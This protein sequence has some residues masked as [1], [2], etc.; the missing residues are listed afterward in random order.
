[1]HDEPITVAGDGSQTRSICYI[2]DT[3][4]G[5]LAL[6]ASSESGPINIGNGD[7]MSMLELAERIEQLVGSSSPI[8]FV[9]LPLDDPK[10]RC[11]DISLARR[12]LGWQPHID[13]ETGLTKTIEWFLSQRASSQRS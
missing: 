1:M 10:V 3:V 13:A 6:A 9:D 8:T 4:A 12:L 11:P 2:D 7:E 5:I